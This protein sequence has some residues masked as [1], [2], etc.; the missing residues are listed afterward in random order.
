MSTVLKKKS[1]LIQA[2]TAKDVWKNGETTRIEEKR[3]SPFVVEHLDEISAITGYDLEMTNMELYV[4]DFRADIVCR[5]NN[6]GD[7]VV[8]ENQLDQSDHD[9]LGKALTYLTNLDAK[10]IIWIC[11]DV[12]PEH[13]K[14]IEKLNEITNDEY[15]FY[16]LELKFG[17]CNK[18][19]IYYEF[20]ER[21]VP[22]V[23][24]KLANQI[25]TVSDGFIEVSTFFSKFINELK[26]YIPTVRFNKAKAYHFIYNKN[27]AMWAHVMRS[28]RD[29]NMFR[30][31]I[32]CDTTKLPPNCNKDEYIEK[33]QEIKKELNDKGYDFEMEHGKKKS[34]IYKL[35]WTTD[36]SNDNVETYK[37]ACID[38]YNTLLKYWQ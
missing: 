29:L 30:I 25:R 3:M 2:V 19:D 13:L 18:T 36:F 23:I 21:F 27:A 10:G 17:C 1:E 8:I 32:D 11:E 6:T 12:R 24:N 22:N 37:T 33:M 9:H 14:A 15:N 7:V 26:E 34:D 38:V 5:D 35:L 16:F 28:T 4:G 20:K 31:E